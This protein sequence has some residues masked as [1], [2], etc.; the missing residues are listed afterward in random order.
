MPIDRI[1]R[2][3]VFESRKW[4]RIFL[5]STASRSVLWPAQADFYWIPE[6]L[7]LGDQADGADYSPPFNAEVKN[8]GN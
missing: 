3:T 2:E 1:T 6:F 8:T 5:F 4:D 7:S